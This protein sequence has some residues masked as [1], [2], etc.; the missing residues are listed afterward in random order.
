[1]ADLWPQHLDEAPPGDEA[2]QP[3]GHQLLHADH[4]RGLVQ[5]G[6]EGHV[7]LNQLQA[8]GQ[9]GQCPVFVVLINLIRLIDRKDEDQNTKS[10]KG[11]R[12]FMMMMMMMMMSTFTAHDSIHLNARCA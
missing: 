7:V 6:A 1:M 4:R 10:L 3:A 9:D 11:T 5:R 2:R 8:N 12:G